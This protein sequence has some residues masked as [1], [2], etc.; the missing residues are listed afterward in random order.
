MIKNVRPTT[1]VFLTPWTMISLVSSASRKLYLMVAWVTPLSSLIG[2]V[3]S[4]LIDLVAFGVE[5]WTCDEELA[6][7]FA[8]PSKA[9]IA[10]MMTTTKIIE[11]TTTQTDLLF[12]Y[13]RK[14][15]MW[16]GYYKS[17]LEMSMQ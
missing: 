8:A 10:K 13:W 9:L 16:E 1:E 14:L 3:R 15:A 2:M 12:E 11:L 6:G 17:L 4:L 7:L 5:S